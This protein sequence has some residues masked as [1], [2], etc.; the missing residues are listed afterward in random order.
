MP[1]LKGIKLLD[2]LPPAALERIAARCLWSEHKAGGTLIQQADQSND[3]YFLTAGRAKAVIYSSNGK[4][5]AFR[6]IAA[7]DTF[8]ELAAL[9]GAPRSASI[10]AIEDCTLAALAAT[11]FWNALDA[12]PEM[13]R[14][15]FRQLVANIRSLSDRVYEFSTF[16]VANRIQAELLRLSRGGENADGSAIVAPH[17]KH[18]DIAERISTHREAVAR[19]F[20][21]LRELGLIDRQGDVLVIKDTAR[22]ARMVAEATGE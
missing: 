9:D 7:G 21:R 3:V 17:P 2:G 15:L 11:D 8:G 12:E 4:A 18:A 16:A 10:E 6:D 13:R 19:E 20:S 22:L 5:V 1:R 14:R